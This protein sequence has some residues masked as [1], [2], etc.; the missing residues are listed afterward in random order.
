MHIPDGYLG[1]TTYGSLWA[2][3]A[4]VWYFASQKVQK[5]LSVSR[6]PFLA[7]S[8]AFSF[9]VMIFT[10]P[11]PGG[12]SGHIAGATLIA[13]LLGPWP[14]TMAVSIAL[15]IQALLFGDGGIT[16]LGANC[17]NIAFVGSFVGYGANALFLKA[18]TVFKRRADR[19]VIPLAIRLTGAGVGA[20]VGINAAALFTAV[21]LGMQPIIYAA[22][23]GASGYFPFPLSIVLPAVMIPHLTMVG[24]LESGVSAL[25]LFFLQK[26][27]PQITVR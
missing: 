11:L 23:S 8:S 27:Q 18:A 17:F 6:V 12:T 13:I 22:G 15:I 19:A 3:T 1:P 2:A 7:M 24:A 5:G 21:E 10:I 26:F 20:Y 16:T 14:A 25:V 9:L 4:A